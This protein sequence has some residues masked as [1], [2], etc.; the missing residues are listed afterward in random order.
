MIRSIVIGIV[1]LS[2]C[3]CSDTAVQEPLT[4]AE[5]IEQGIEERLSNLKARKMKDCKEQ[6]LLDV[7]TEVDSLIAQ[8]LQLDMVDT[9][10][11]P[12]RPMRPRVPD[13]RIVLDTSPVQ[14]V[15]NN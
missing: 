4:R 6:L 12:R 3:S 11:F 10:A 13:G 2:A 7:L 9:V 8:R 1:L 15:L 14:K 5:L